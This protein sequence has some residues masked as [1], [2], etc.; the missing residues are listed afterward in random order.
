MSTV[1]TPPIERVHWVA[2]WVSAAIECVALPS[3]LLTQPSQ[4]GLV[5]VAKV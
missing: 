3:W 4:L 1:Q 2:V 5:P